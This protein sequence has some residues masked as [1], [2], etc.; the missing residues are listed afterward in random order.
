MQ[1]R[2]VVTGVVTALAALGAAGP[3]QASI[4]ATSGEVQK[5]PQPSTAEIGKLES[6]L[7]ARAWDEAQSHRLTAPLTV[8]KTPAGPGTTIPAGTWVSS[9][10][11]HADQVGT[12]GGVTFTGSATF[13]SSIIG[14]VTTNAGLVASD[15]LGAPTVFSATGR[16][17]EPGS[18][19]VTVSASA[20]T[21]T[22]NNFNV[23]DEVRIITDADADDDGV[24][25]GSDNCRTTA[26]P[27]QADAD[28]DGI[29]DACD[30]LTY[31]FDGFYAPIDNAPTVNTT[32][33]GSAIPVKFSLGGYQGLEILAAGSPVS[34][35]EGCGSGA[36]DTIETITAGG[37]SLSYD[38][39]S[40]T[41]TYVWKTS[42]EWSGQCRTLVVT[43]A[44][45]GRHTALFEFS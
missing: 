9:H 39:A 3:A 27:D 12:L 17:P 5:V 35:E 28:G 22:F 16:A 38:A 25:D 40:D 8:D 41:Y 14:A 45:G 31:R 42:K 21:V 44:D 13:D 37:S 43:T 1:S 4:T 23:V 6:D 36:P 19:T 20:T 32:K 11:I 24:I 26:N 15:Y 10:M 30:S 18:D 33:A 34:V 29:G 2:T 7:V